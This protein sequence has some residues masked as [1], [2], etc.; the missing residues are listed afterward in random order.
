MAKNRGIE[1]KKEKNKKNLKKHI[2]TVD[3]GNI[4]VVI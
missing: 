1:K 4:G 2:K 3:R